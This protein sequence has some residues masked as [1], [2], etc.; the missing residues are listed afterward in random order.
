[1]ENLL[2]RE[3]W[4]YNANVRN[5]A[6][7][8]WKCSDERIKMESFIKEFVLLTP[9]KYLHKCARK[10]KW[11]IAY[12]LGHKLIAKEIRCIAFRKTEKTE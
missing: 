6:Q 11:G 3:I 9:F 8:L 5:M 4:I 10:G 7:G 2:F 1:M 12:R